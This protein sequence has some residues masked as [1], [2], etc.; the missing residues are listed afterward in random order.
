[1]ASNYGMD[2]DPYEMLN[3]KPGCT[4]TQI[5][6]AFRKAALKWHPDKNYDRKEAGIFNNLLVQGN[7]QVLLFLGSCFLTVCFRKFNLSN[8]F[9]ARNVPEN[10]Q[11]F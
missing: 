10:I 7:P 11:S 6:K 3:L 1:M 2:F 4:D 5:V 8:N 9:S